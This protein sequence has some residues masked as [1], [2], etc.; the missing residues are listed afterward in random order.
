MTV[1]I[2]GAGVMGETLLAGLLRSG[3]PTQEL[4]IAERRDLF[5]DTKVER[6]DFLLSKRG[7]RNARRP[8]GGDG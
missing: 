5:D 6:D 1:G 3:M 7:Q 4:L 8:L 2:I